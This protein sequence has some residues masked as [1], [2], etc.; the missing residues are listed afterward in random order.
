MDTRWGNWYY[1]LKNGTMAKDTT[2]DGYVL[3][4]NGAWDNTS[5]KRIE[6]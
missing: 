1:L 5:L 3:D 2:I 4:S 6:L